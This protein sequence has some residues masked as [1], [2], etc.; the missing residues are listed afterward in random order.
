[1]ATQGGDSG[2]CG[3]AC[4]P[5]MVGVQEGL[6]LRTKSVEVT[7]EQLSGAAGAE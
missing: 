2:R 6:Q 5:R 1:M 7:E 3:Q 4:A